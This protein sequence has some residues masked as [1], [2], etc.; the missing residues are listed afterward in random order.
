MIVRD[1]VLAGRSFSS[2]GELDQ[3][4]LAWVPA[5]RRTVHRTHGEVIGVRAQR[6]H[7]ALAPV[8]ARPYVVANRHLRHVGKDCLVAFEANLY[9]VPAA[10]VSHRQL[11][12]VRARAATISLHAT[13]PDENGVTL[14]AVHPPRS[15]AAPASPTPT[16][17]SRCRTGTPAPPLPAASPSPAATTMT[18]DAAAANPLARCSSCWPG[19]TREYHCR[20]PAAVGL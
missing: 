18:A 17:G 16:T 3:A 2:L 1:H 8:P 13:V 6:D 15:A 9:S 11:V 5:R 10:R 12:E 20:A 7:A 4:F 19:R 14:L